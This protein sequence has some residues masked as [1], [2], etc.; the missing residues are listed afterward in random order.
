MLRS[1]FEMIKNFVSVVT[2]IIQFVINLV[3]SL[4]RFIV[5]I[6]TYLTS[7]INSINLLP[8]YIIPFATA[9]VFISVIMLLINRKGGSDHG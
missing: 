2:S 8:A 5:M 7:V 6:P 9:T 4:V 3:V 1:I